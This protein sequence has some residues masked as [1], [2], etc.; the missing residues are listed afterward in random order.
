MLLHSHGA[1]VLQRQEPNQK[2]SGSVPELTA[3]LAPNLGHGASHLWEYL[4]SEKNEP[5][6][7]GVR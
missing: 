5:F 2:E 4:A 7:G 1:E 6:S 3:P